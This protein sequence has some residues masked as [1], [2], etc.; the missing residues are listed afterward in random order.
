MRNHMPTTLR[1]LCRPLIAL[2]AIFGAS[3]ASEASAC[4]SMKPGSGACDSACECCSPEATGAPT[5]R[6]EVAAERAA[7]P[8]AP[9]ACQ[10][11]PGGGCSC[12]SQEPAAPTPK[13]DRN[14]AEGRSELGQ[15]SD[16]VHRGDEAAARALLSPRV[17][18]TQSP[19][20]IPLYLRNS[21]LLF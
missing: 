17:T 8:E 11:T 3:L 18:P 7:L 19:P 6:V 14:T 21:R 10:R 5:N 9:V 13:P 2:A 16:F 15:G 4:S 12:R 20:K 1:R